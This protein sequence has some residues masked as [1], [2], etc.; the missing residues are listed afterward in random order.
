MYQTYM[1][2]ANAR[3]GTRTLDLSRGVIKRASL[4]FVYSLLSTLYLGSGASAKFPLGS[5]YVPLH[6]V[7]GRYPRHPFYRALPSELHGLNFSFQAFS[8]SSSA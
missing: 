6:G 5:P 8:L 7:L 1:W 2:F 4:P 3:E